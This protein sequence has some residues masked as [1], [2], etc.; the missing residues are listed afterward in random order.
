VLERTPRAEPEKSDVLL[1]LNPFE[2][3]N[4]Y[5]FIL[6]T[7]PNRIDIIVERMN[8]VTASSGK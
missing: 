4:M 8:P 7:I 3:L 5:R 1:I 6:T 2:C